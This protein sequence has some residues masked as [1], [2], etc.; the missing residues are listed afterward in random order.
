MNRLYR[1]LL[2]VPVTAVAVG[3]GTIRDMIKDMQHIHGCVTQRSSAQ[4]ININMTTSK[5]FTIGLVNAPI[6]TLPTAARTA[7]VRQVAEC[8]RDNYRRYT[9]LTE[10]AVVFIHR[11][12]TGGVKVSESGA[13]II[14]TTRELGQ[15]AS[16]PADSAA[17][18]TK[19]PN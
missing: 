16:P 2:I 18:R 1:G 6:D 10:V 11:R 5:R 19:A 9:S 15:P 14:Y 7:A 4:A 12:T 3:C 17:G 8:V 13:P